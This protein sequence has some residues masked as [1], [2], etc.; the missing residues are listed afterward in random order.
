MTRF[1]LLF[2]LDTI[3]SN[4]QRLHAEAVSEILR[5][6]RIEITPERI[7]AEY[8]DKSS[9][10]IFE[11]E[12]EKARKRHCVPNPTALRDQ[13]WLRMA[14]LSE[15]NVCAIPGSVALIRRMHTQNVPL[16]ITT[17]APRS[18]AELVLRASGV[19]PCF[20]VIASVHDREVAR[21][22]PHPDVFARAA[23]LLGMEPR[24]CIAIEHRPSGMHGAKAAGMCC[25][26]FVQDPSMA[27]ASA[28][29][30]LSDLSAW[31]P[32]AALTALAA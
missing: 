10:F 15:K 19:R 28:D 4:L 25:A 16:A 23:Q 12:V 29:W 1:A 9:R 17:A 32:L 22:K 30:V 14:T 21:P 11:T 31:D 2:G 5:E 8:P 27:I 6:Y 24:D 18:F 13:K 26:A 7:I 20:R 3:A